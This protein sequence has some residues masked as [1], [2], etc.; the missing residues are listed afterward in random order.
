MAHALETIAECGILRAHPLLTFRAG[1]YSYRIERKGDESLYTVSIGSESL[2]F[3]LQYAF[4][5]GFA[6]QTYVFEHDGKLYESLVSFYK[7]INGLDITLGDGNVRP[8]NLLEAAGRELSAP[9]A[10][11]CFSCHSTNALSPTKSLNLTAA[12]PGVQCERCHGETGHHLEG[13]AKGDASLFAMKSIKGMSAEETAHFCGQC[14]RTWEQIASNGPRGTANVRFQPYRLT[15]SRC[16]D[17]DDKR[18]ACVA[19]HDPHQEIDRLPQHY[20]GKCQAC[21]DGGKPAAKPCPVSSSNCSSC[22]MPKIE[23]QGGHHKFSDHDIRI[24]RTNSP[25]PG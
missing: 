18:I 24:V 15:N 19:C 17:P 7:E 4:G 21:H 1:N 12:T 8:A 5:L 11:L 20:D 23:L 22:H 9:E 25:Y 10:T 13:L 14:H 2:S 16:Y 3:P 6:G